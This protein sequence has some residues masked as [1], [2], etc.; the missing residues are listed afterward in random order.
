[1]KHVRVLS[2]RGAALIGCGIGLIACLACN[3]AASAD[4]FGPISLASAGTLAGSDYAQQAES[5]GDAVISGDGRYVAFEGSFAGRTGIFRRDLSSG[6]VAIVALGDAQQPSI[7]EDGR[8]VSFTTTARLDEQNDTNSAPDVYVRDMDK[9]DSQPC[10][11]GWEESSTA[12]EACAF[13][14]ASAVDGGSQG[15]AYAYGSNQAFEETHY[16]SVASGRSAL[17][18]DGRTVVFLTT[19]T[20]NLA[21]PGRSAPPHSLE[22]PETPPMQVAVRKLDGRITELVSVVRDPASGGARLERIG[23]AAAGARERRRRR[24]GVSGWLQQLAAGAP[25]PEP[26]E[27]RVDQRGRLDRRL[28]GPAGRRAGAGAVRLRPS[29][30]ARLH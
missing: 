11:V 15:L 12:V 13:T 27:R 24:R 14:L 3:S 6:E 22:A 10:P 21:N 26:M 20:S 28:D 1:M 8:Y 25:V 23:T 19:A 4:V 17:S 18:S 16:G 9:T 7:S 5:A 2:H 30:P 29:Q